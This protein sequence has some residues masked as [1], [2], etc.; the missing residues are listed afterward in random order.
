[1]HMRKDNPMPDCC[2]YDDITWGE[3]L[4]GALWL[5]TC[6]PLFAWATVVARAAV[7]GPR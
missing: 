5:L 7:G 1:M 3:A 6:W 4:C 2:D